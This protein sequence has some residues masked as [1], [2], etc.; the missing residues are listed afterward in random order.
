MQE[1]G[2]NL[3]VPLSQMSISFSLAHSFTRSLARICAGS[4]INIS[5]QA[6]KWIYSYHIL[7]KTG[8][9]IQDPDAVSHP[10]LMGLY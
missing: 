6:D 2:A 3:K 4:T 5:K 1:K 8:S 7:N 10:Q 9:M